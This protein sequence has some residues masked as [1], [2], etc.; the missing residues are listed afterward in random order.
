[1][2]TNKKFWNFPLIL[3]GSLIKNENIK[4]DTQTHREKDDLISLIAKIRE[5]TQTVR[6]PHKGKAI[7][8]TGRGDP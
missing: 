1:V 4:G 8:V 5:N 7:P 6:S 3:H 2:I